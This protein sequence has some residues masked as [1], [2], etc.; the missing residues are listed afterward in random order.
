MENH[1][2]GLLSSHLTFYEKLGNYKFFL[3]KYPL[4][5]I[6]LELFKIYQN[7]KFQQFSYAKNDMGE[8]V[9]AG[10]YIYAI[11]AGVFKATKKMV[12]LK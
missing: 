5:K 7:L 3:F 9:A 8:R 4:K 1:S 11:Q 10:M 2:N 6:I 12:L